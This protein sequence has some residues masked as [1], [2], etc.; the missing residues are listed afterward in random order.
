[1]ATE[2]ILIKD[3]SAKTTIA[4]DDLVIIGEGNDA[5]KMTIAQLKE[6][7]G[8]NALNTK[9]DVTDEIT[10]NNQY[11][12]ITSVYKMGNIVMIVG[13][14]K[15]GFASGWHTTETITNPY[16]PIAET[17]LTIGRNSTARDGGTIL[18]MALTTDNRVA[19]YITAD[20]NA[21]VGF[22]AVY[23]CAS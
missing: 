12:Q 22:S 18:K 5:K 15:T 2:G 9:I 20:L 21:D 7:L 4:D 10:S 3:L 23:I 16:P 17:A 13:A 1:M 11:I 14:F 19:G 8:I 6:E